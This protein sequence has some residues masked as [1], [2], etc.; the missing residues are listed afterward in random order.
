MALNGGQAMRFED[1]LFLIQTRGLAAENVRQLYLDAERQ[2]ERGEPLGLAT[3]AGRRRLLAGLS[4]DALARGRVIAWP[5]SQA[6]IAR[7][8]ALLRRAEARLAW[9]GQPD[10]PTKI[11]D[12]MGDEAPPWLLLAGCEERL[13]GPGAAMIGSR[14]TTPAYLEGAR[15][16]GRALADGGAAVV[17]GMAIGADTAAHEGARAGR[18]G[19]VIVPATGLLTA[20][21]ALSVGLGA[22]QNW[23]G[24]DRP[25]APF[26]AGLAI[27]RNDVIAALGDVLVLVASGLKGGSSYGV[28]WALRHGVTIFCFEN[29]AATPPANGA[30]IRAGL[31]RPLALGARAEAWVEAIMPEIEKRR[32]AGGAAGLERNGVATRA[33]QLDFL[34]V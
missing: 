21:L 22:V 32:A 5:S 30:L 27:R 29:G 8:A 11:A 25:D 34:G 26:S 18:A 4:P 15:R 20:G 24:L 33:A 12:T 2:L 16:L 1:Q 9:R 28:R 31:A 3:E 17:S 7:M 14:Q 13:G 6:A 23:V 19:T 10:Y